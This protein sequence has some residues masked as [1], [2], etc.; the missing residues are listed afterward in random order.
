M[1]KSK[2]FSS[3]DAVVAQLNEWET[4]GYNLKNNFIRITQEVTPVQVSGSQTVFNIFYDAILDN[5]H[6]N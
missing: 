4:N 3:K 1:I 6:Y 2:T 5:K